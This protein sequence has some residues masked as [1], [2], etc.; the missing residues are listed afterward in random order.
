M[1]AAL[2]ALKED[3]VRDARPLLRILLAAVVLILLIACANLAN[4]LLVRAAGRRREFGVRLALGAARRAM[5]RH[6]LTESLL[7]SAI[8][9]LLGIALACGAS[10]FRG[11]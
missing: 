2:R 9:G 6:L 3:T 4:L 10:P 7:L 8:G 5:L 1:H 11:G